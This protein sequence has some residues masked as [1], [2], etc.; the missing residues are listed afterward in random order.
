MEERTAIDDDEPVFMPRH[1]TP[2]PRNVHAARRRELLGQRPATVWL[3]GFSGAGKS[4]I[5]VALENRLLELGQLATVLDGDGLRQGI[6]ADLGFS[7]SDREE[8]VRRTAE[9]AALFNAAGVIVIVALISPTTAGREAA[10]SIIG[11]DR[12]LEVH[13][14]T[15]LAVCERRDPKGLYQKVRAGLIANFTGIS[16]NYQPPVAPALSLDTAQ[17]SAE[18]CVARLVD[19]LL[20]QFDRSAKNDEALP[21]G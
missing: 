7:E 9:I 16:A 15:E 17:A 2:H 10:R 18:D 8:N 19:M 21:G 3:T 1:I 13:V 14:A 20:P 6:N 11:A 5:A 12:F 4:T